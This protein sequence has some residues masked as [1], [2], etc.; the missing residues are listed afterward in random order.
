MTSEQILYQ[1]HM[2]A[3]RP[4]SILHWLEISIDGITTQYSGSAAPFT[5]ADGQSLVLELHRDGDVIS[6][7]LKRPLE[8]DVEPSVVASTINTQ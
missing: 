3:L 8:S 1:T 7:T 4:S 6:A 5:L 2:Q